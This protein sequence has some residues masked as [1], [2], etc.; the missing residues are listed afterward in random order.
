[1]PKGGTY[2]LVKI[3]ND[4][5]NEEK[6]EVT[7]DKK[8]RESQYSNQGKAKLIRMLDYYSN[9]LEMNKPIDV[10]KCIHSCNFL[11]FFVKKESLKEKKL[12]QEIIKE[13][14]EILRNPEKKYAKKKNTWQLYKEVEAELD[15]PN[16]ELISKIETWI[17]N[18]VFNLDI[19]LEK[20]DYLKI[21][22][23][24]D[25]EKIT[26]DI[27]EKE[28]RRYVLPNLYNSNDYNI[29]INEKVF[30]L[31][32]DNMGM[33]AKKPFLAH[34]S[35]GLLEI[36]YCLNLEDALMQRR[37]FDYL[38][39]AVSNGKYNIYFSKNEYEKGIFS[40]SDKEF[41][42]NDFS[43]YYLRVSKGKNE[44]EIYD[45][46]VV[47]N[48][49]AN[50]KTPIK[51]RK[52]FD[53][54]DSGSSIDEKIGGKN[55]K[56][57]VKYKYKKNQHSDIYTAKELQGVINDVFFSNYLVNN[58]FTAPDDLS[59]SDTHIKE[60][61]LFYRNS[62]WKWIRSGAKPEM[63]M[64]R[65]FD[66]ISDRAIMGSIYNNYG[67]KAM[68]QFCLK[69][70]LK[71]YF[72]YSSEL[73][74][75]MF[76]TGEMLKEVILKN[77]TWNFEDDESYYYGVGQLVQYFLSKSKV[78]KKTISFIIPYLNAKSY[79]KI[80]ELLTQMLSKYSYDMLLKS[81]ESNLFASV[82]AYTPKGNVNKDFMIQGFLD[83]SLIYLERKKENEEE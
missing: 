45:F 24:Y 61:I 68:D 23:H 63:K 46:R 79:V 16:D 75:K 6:I 39:N 28:Y 48:F 51:Y 80:K 25:N 17:K 36:P 59:I 7:F 64:A 4:N 53:R 33:N 35:R 1:M 21:F 49:D 3:D 82:F 37:F 14:Y 30:G 11:S 77:E 10:K 18:N 43:G 74:D 20:K 19:D 44:A 62:I 65:I 72:K 22:F 29:I 50:L 70:S 58:Y 15:K 60:N 5:F 41:P 83:T 26:E 57:E 78:G 67:G 56:K 71:Q 32:N 12:T 2:Y 34:K 47:P 69:Q 42:D 40:L 13:Y 55:K 38:M 27:Y 76:K 8:A 52:Y 31:P 73:E 54:K 81:R 66:N 9:L